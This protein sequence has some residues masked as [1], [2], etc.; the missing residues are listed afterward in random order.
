MNRIEKISSLIGDVALPLFG[1]FFWNWNFYF[2]L[3]FFMLDQLAR[4]IFLPQRLKLIETSSRSESRI[5]FVGS[6]CGFIFLG[7]LV[8]NSGLAES[9]AIFIALIALTVGL[10]FSTK[11][12]NL[13][14]FRLAIITHLL[15][16]T[17]G[18]ATILIAPGFTNRNSL[19][20]QTAF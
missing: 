17:I 19:D 6:L 10:Q 20:T 11:S 15:G 14:R 8:G 4:V 9:S 16:V 18:L 7:F 3:L 5:Y 2:I 13:S 1:Y 12:N